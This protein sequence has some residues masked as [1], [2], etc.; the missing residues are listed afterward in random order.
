MTTD[1]TTAEARVLLVGSLP[2]DSAEESYRAAGP[3]IGKYGY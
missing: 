2:F 3:T 1:T